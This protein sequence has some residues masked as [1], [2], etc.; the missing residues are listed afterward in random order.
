VKY[1]IPKSFSFLL[2][3]VSNCVADKHN[4]V[5]GLHVVGGMVRLGKKI[6]SFNLIHTG[7]N[8]FSKYICGMYVLLV[9]SF[10]VGK[11]EVWF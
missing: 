1:C 7:H 6:R 9:L 8:T 11:V 10:Q 2:C 5:K 4:V 3:C